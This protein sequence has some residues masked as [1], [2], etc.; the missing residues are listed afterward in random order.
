MWRWRF[1]GLGSKEFDAQF[2]QKRIQVS[3]AQNI[4]LNYR[5]GINMEADELT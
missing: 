3:V 5:F 2:P 1:I 4:V